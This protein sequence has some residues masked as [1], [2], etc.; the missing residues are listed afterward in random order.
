MCTRLIVNLSQTYISVYLTD[1]LMLPK[2]NTHTHTL[3]SY[4]PYVASICEMLH[5]KSDLLLLY[6]ELHCHHTSGRLY[7]QLRVLS[8]HETSQQEHR[9][10]CECFSFH[11]HRCMFC[12][13]T[14]WTGGDVLSQR[15]DLCVSKESRNTDAIQQINT[16]LPQAWRGE[17]ETEHVGQNLIQCSVQLFYLEFFFIV[18]IV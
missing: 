14:F 9:N 3:Y 17:K 15:V 6:S 7:Q 8:G 13:V 2:V 16:V 11:G 5:F 1:S 10:Q 12:V 4:S 18:C